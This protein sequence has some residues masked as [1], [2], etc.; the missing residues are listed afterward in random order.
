MDNYKIPRI[1]TERLILRAVSL[2]DVEDM[3]EY[4]SD[5][6][7]VLDVTFP[8]HDSIEATKLSIETVFLDRP[9]RGNPEAFAIVLKENNKMIGTCDFF[10]GYGSD[11]YE[12]GYIL[13]KKYWRQGYMFEAAQAVLKFAFES[14]GVRRMMIR[15]LSEN[16]KSEGL[17]K[18]LGFKFEGELR[19]LL[20]NKNGTYSDV[21]M[22][23]M[24]KE[25]Y[26]NE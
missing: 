12:M 11:T 9:L 13:N 15:H 14:F 1:E 8:A 6:E 10:K 18:K 20:L 2:E 5:E 7:T 25:D 19:K 22:Y 21:K 16:V 23:S 4:A 17:I 3:F 24:L 26:F